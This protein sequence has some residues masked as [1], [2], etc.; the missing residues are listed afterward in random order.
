MSGYQVAAGALLSLG[1]AA[2]VVWPRQVWRFGRG[3][4]FADPDAVR[5]SPAYVAWLRLSGAVG[6]ALGIGL[7][8]YAAR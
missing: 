1:G 7:V 6:V 8:A 5:V 4:R 2:L 3:W